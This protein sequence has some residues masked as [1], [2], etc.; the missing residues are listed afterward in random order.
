MRGAG[1]CIQ[2]TC[3]TKAPCVQVALGL[4]LDKAGVCVFMEWDTW[5]KHHH[6]PYWDTV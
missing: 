2:K 4:P 5:E 6:G 1:T 3:L